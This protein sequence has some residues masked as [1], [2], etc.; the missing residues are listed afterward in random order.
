MEVIIL[1]SGTCIPANDRASPSLLLRTAQGPLIVDMGPGTLRRLV[2]I[3][4]SFEKIKHICITH[5]HPDHTADLI[6][7]L[8]ATRNPQILKKRTPFTLTAPK[9]IRDLLAGLEKV[10]GNW[11]SLPPEIMIMDELDTLKKDTR[12]CPCFNI[13]SQPTEHTP[14]SVAYR[15]EDNSGKRM[16]YS[17]DTGVCDGMFD[18]AL[19]CD[20]LILEC[21]FPDGMD[22]AG[23]LTPSLAGQMANDCRAK[24]LLLLHFY[25][26]VL[27]T[28]IASACR[29]FFKGE[30]VLGRDNLH[31]RI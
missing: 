12:E 30:L 20:L 8:F 15:F 6:H 7:F 9:G 3:G 10:Y 17:G 23:H 1:G 13:T 11:L 19:D 28:D 25:P 22:M 24:K 21:S 31:V 14:C 2:S 18:L 27:A 29:R 16:V 5:F 26:E 4:I